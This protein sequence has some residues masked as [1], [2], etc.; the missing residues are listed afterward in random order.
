MIGLILMMRVIQWMNRS[1]GKMNVKEFRFI[2]AQIR[3]LARESTT[4]TDLLKVWDE[5]IITLKEDQK[6]VDGFTII[7]DRE[8]LDKWQ[9][10]TEKQLEH[11]EVLRLLFNKNKV[12]YPLFL[13][14][15]N[16]WENGVG[17]YI[18]EYDCIDAT[19]FEEMNKEFKEK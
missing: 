19:H 2:D 14:I 9:N 5:T 6:M 8:A 11:Y 18:Y 7:K 10:E 1:L 13:Y 17:S 3:K 12:K 15:D 16:E 4:N